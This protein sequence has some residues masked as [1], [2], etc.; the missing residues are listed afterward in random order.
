MER[1]VCSRLPENL[2]TDYIELN[3]HKFKD[4]K[5]VSFDGKDKNDSIEEFVEFY[6]SGNYSHLCFD[7][8]L[9]FKNVDVYRSYCETLYRK[10]LDNLVVEF[11][12]MAKFQ[13]LKKLDGSIKVVML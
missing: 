2:F 13:L 5:L 6:K 9:Y 12:K 4:G 8:S 1:S 11:N 3:F 7:F 10:L